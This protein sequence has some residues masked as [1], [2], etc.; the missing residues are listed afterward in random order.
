MTAQIPI[1]ESIAMD[2]SCQ[3]QYWA[4]GHH[5]P[6]HFGVAVLDHHKR[7]R[8]KLIPFDIRK[9]RQLYWRKVRAGREEDQVNFGEGFK[10]IESDQ[11]PG[12]FAV[13]VYENWLPLFKDAR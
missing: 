13:T 1:E 4:R 3:V 8:G 12:A 7:E 10:F 2:D 11:G 6:L 5:Q 9:V